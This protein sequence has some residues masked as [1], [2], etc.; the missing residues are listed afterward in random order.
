MIVLHIVEHFLALYTAFHDVML[1]NVRNMMWNLT[2]FSKL[3]NYYL[4]LPF[5]HLIKKEV[6]LMGKHVMYNSK[7]ST[8]PPI[9]TY[10]FTC[11]AIDK[12]NI[13]FPSVSMS[14]GQSVG[15]QCFWQNLS[16][17]LC[18][19]LKWN[20]S[21]ERITSEKKVSPCACKWDC[22]WQLLS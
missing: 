19:D 10:T 16:V 8:N 1:Q 7:I 2:W 17:S 14:S 5:D 12:L 15:L 20:T 21:T 13:H 18:F 4:V 22:R 3:F 9:H 11:S 6:I